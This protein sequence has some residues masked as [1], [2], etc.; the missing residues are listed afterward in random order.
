MSATDFQAYLRGF[1]DGATGVLEFV[2][3]LLANGFGWIAALEAAQEWL[4]IVQRNARDYAL[5]LDFSD[6]STSEGEKI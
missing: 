2:R 3:K 1:Q 5:S 4:Q 6:Q